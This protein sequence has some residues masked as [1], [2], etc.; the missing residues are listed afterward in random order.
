M[1]ARLAADFPVRMLHFVYVHQKKYLACW[2]IM[3]I[4]HVAWLLPKCP[5][6]EFY[7]PIGLNKATT[8]R[9][10]L[11]KCRQFR[12][13]CFVRSYAKHQT[14]PLSHCQRLVPTVTSIFTYAGWTYFAKGR[15]RERLGF[16]KNPTWNAFK[17]K[18]NGIH[19]I[20]FLIKKD[21]RWEKQTCLRKN[22]NLR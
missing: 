6:C 13:S 11:L 19:T 2:K 18:S 9:I 12:K 16:T 14:K 3:S 10:V 7:K 5:M 8:R 1:R 20:T 4:F 15:E 21:N 17:D 22:I